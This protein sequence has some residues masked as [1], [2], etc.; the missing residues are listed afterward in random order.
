[1]D[2]QTLQRALGGD[3][4]NGQLLCPGPGHSPADRSLS[5]KLNPNAPDGFVVHS[6]SGDDPITCKDHV[7]EKAGLPTFVSKA[8]KGN[9]NGKRWTFISEHIYRTETDEPYL[10]VRKYRDENNKK[11]YPQAQWHEGQWVKGKPAG[12][13]IPYRLPELI[14]AAPTTQIFFAEGEKDADALAELGF[15]ATTA[16]EG[17]AAKWDDG[18]TH[19]FKDKHVVILP[20]A[21]VPGRAHAQKVAKAINNIAASVRVLDLCPNRQDGSDAWDWIQDDTAGSKLAAMA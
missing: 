7:R 4:S 6:F 8:K 3:I 15:V 2:L 16:S 1:M 18:L 12:G 10:R 9:G 20:H 19:Y 11:H 5:I 17:A 21:D 13:K 14:A